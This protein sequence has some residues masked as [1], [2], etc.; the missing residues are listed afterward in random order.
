MPVIYYIAGNAGCG[1]WIMAAHQPLIHGNEIHSNR[2]SGISLVNKMDTSHNNETLMVTK[3]DVQSEK[4][5]V[6]NSVINRDQQT[7]KHR[8]VTIATVEYNKVFHNNGKGIVVEFG[9]G[10]VVQYNHVHANKGEGVAVD[11]PSHVLVKNNSI[12]CN[13]G[14]GV[15]VSSQGKIEIQ[16]NGIYDN[17]DHGVACEN[18]AVIFENDIL[19]NG[20]TGIQLAS[21]KSVQVKCNRVCVPKEPAVC[22]LGVQEGVVDDNILYS[23]SSNC[24]SADKKTSCMVLNNHTVP[25]P[26]VCQSVGGE[27]V[28]TLDK[29]RWL[30]T[31]PAPRPHIILPPQLSYAPAHHVTT[32]TKVTVPADNCEHGSR[33]CVIL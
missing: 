31:D 10:V 24:I 29:T 21:N 26:Q 25:P 3:S 18:E 17:K 33:F 1:I 19:G 30:L 23:N 2:D 22:L 14:T 7:V 16:G 27:A 32:I 20:Q 12:T 9:D 4:S 11:Q 5:L 6:Y 28:T 8:L 13:S 15:L